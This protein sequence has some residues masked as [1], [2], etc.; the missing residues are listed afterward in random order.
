[1]RTKEQ[2]LDAFGKGL[3][4]ISSCT[5]EKHIECARR[6]CYQLL[7]QESKQID[8]NRFETSDF[9]MESYLKLTYVIKQKEEELNL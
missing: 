5:T 9:A 4:I 8:E 3:N 2:V 6:Y 1:M 7:N